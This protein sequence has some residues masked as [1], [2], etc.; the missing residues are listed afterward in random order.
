LSKDHEG[1]KR[2]ANRT[3]AQ[4]RTMSEENQFNF[5]SCSWR[6]PSKAQGKG[7]ARGGNFT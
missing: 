7:A 5:Y 3:L 6:D 1:P 4:V 2:K